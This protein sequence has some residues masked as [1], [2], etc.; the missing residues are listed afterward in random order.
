MTNTSKSTTEKSVIK[1]PSSPFVGDPYNKR[2]GQGGK[3]GFADNA[4]GGAKIKPS[5]SVPKFK[6]GSGGDR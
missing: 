3:R 6:G 2:G 5:I 4:A 1:K